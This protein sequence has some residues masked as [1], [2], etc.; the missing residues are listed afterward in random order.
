MSTM[1][2]ECNTCGKI[3]KRESHYVSHRVFCEEM[4]KSRQDTMNQMELPSSQV[5]YS[6]MHQL[7]LKVDRLQKEV[8]T[9]R[10]QVKSQTKTNI[11][12]Y[13]NANTKVT[14][15]ELAYLFNDKDGIQRRNIFKFND[16]KRDILKDILMDSS[17]DECVVRMI[18]YLFKEENKTTHPV[19]AFTTHNNAVYIY[20]I[21]NE[22]WRPMSK[23]D[24]IQ[25]TNY[26]HSYVLNLFK[27]W[28]DSKAENI[29]NDNWFYSNMYVPTMN[30]ILKATISQSNMRT[31]LYDHLKQDVKQFVSLSTE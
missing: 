28:K 6:V 14:T 23:A 18:R 20:D 29:K 30:R 22:K 15:Q 7:L 9:L 8:E 25:F 16:E 27:E 26:C 24:I 2:Y 31:M 12:D 21:D 4:F 5:M 1:N 13:L 10:K 3:Y 19:Q 11:V 17:Y